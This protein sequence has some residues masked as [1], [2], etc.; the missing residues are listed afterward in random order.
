[1]GPHSRFRRRRRSILCVIVLVAVLAAPVTA[2]ASE[3]A[4]GS[5]NPTTLSASGGLVT[6]TVHYSIAPRRH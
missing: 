4:T 3:T 1:M 6:I 5:I 2:R